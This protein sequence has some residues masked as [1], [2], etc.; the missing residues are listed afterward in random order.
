MQGKG[1][2][3]RTTAR[4]G[5]ILGAIE[6]SKPGEKCEHFFSENPR[7]FWEISGKITP[8]LSLEWSKTPFSVGFELFLDFMKV[9]WCVLD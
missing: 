8:K 3:A 2:P 9:I 7:I 6:R 1:C 5:L 4:Y